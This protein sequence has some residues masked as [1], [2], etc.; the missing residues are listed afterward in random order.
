VKQEHTYSGTK[1]NIIVPRMHSNPITPKRSSNRLYGGY[2]TS[3]RFYNYQ[4]SADPLEVFMEFCTAAKDKKTVEDVFNYLHATAINKLGYNFTALGLVNSNSNYLH[5]RL[6]DHISNI[7]SSRILLSET[8]NPIIQSFLNKQKLNIND[9]NFINV[10]YLHNSP[11]VILPLIC[12]DECVGVF[13]AGSNHRNAQFDDFLGVLTNYL[14][15]LVINKQLSD[16]VS[17]EA[18]ID[19]LTGLKNHRGFQEALTKTLKTS[20]EESPASVLMF[21]INNISGINREYGHAK[22]DEVICVV[23]EKIRQSIRNKD[24]AG[25]YGADEI[26]VILPNTHNS[27]AFYMAEYL[28]HIISCSPIDDIGAVKVNVGVATYP[29]CTREQ[30][31]LLIIS[32]QAMLISKNKQDMGQ[33]VIVNAQ[34]IDFWNEMALDSLA[35]VIAKRHCQWGINFEDEIVKKFQSENLTL[36]NNNHIVDVVKSLAGAIDAKDPYT[37]GHSQDVSRFAEALAK[38]ISLPEDEVERI[39][40]GAMLHDVGKIGI[41]ESVLKKPGALN[42]QE[43]EIMKQHPRIGAE[44]VLEPIPALRELIPMVKHHHEHWDGT[45]YPYG[46]AGEN[47]PLGARIVAIADTFHAL[48]SDRPYRKALS[49]DKAVEILR[50]GAG[51]QWDKDLVRRFIRMAPS[52]CTNVNSQ[53]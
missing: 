17:Q 48:V 20:S 7:Y 29:D 2:N 24:I 9:T 42:D 3:Q 41:P 28:N 45:G 12:Q 10:P 53:G 13:I 16:K 11:A 19:S 25:R 43:W 52:L 46:I 50:A 27:E 34:D 33:G 40:L 6:A 47:I 35:K 30:E 26:A 22:G 18:D 32:E 4:A 38:A 44:K 31:K 5:V 39:R 23:A 49:V 14:A 21:D 1:E 37:K 15:L 36:N 8:Q 51:T